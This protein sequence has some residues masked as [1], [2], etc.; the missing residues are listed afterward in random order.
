MGQKHVIVGMRPPLVRKQQHVQLPQNISIIVRPSRVQITAL[1]NLKRQT[2]P[3]PPTPPAPAPAAG[4]TQKPAASA[5]SR[6]QLIKQRRAKKTSVKY[7]STEIAPESPAKIAAIKGQGKGKI[8]VIIG[9][10]PSILEA[11][12]GKLRDQPNIELLTINKPDQRVWPTH[13]WSFFDRHESL[14]NSYEG[15]VFNSTAIK[16]QKARSIQFKNIGGK[17]W[18][19]NL[20]QG[21]N[22]GRSSVYASMQ[23]ALWLGHEH[24]YIF[25]C[26]MNPAGLNGQLHFYGQNP[27]VPPEVRRERFAKEAEFYDHA[28]DKIT[29]TACLKFTFCSAYNPHSFVNKFNKL[30]HRDAVDL[31]LEHAGRLDKN[32]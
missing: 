12:L 27:D 23:I 21:L 31:I 25:G 32:S 16:R 7:V 13:Y 2:T 14:W 9:N 5:V 30:D 28:A 17:D 26:D 10:G 15:Y 29:P 19:H 8:L 18:S 4:H 24:V 22:I 11:D 3:P 1:R 20:L 6:Q